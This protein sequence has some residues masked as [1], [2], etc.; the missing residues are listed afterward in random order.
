MRLYL[1][2][3]KLTRVLMSDLLSINTFTLSS[4]TEVDFVVNEVDKLRKK[5]AIIQIVSFI[6]NTVLVQNLKKEL[7]KKFDDIEIVLLKHEDKNSTVLNLFSINLSIED[8]MNSE[9]FG[10]IIWHL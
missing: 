5:Y 6:H 10:F 2:T 8:V 9:L 4:S 3:I 1:T 7:S